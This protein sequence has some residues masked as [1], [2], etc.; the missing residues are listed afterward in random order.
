MATIMEGQPFPDVTITNTQVQKAPEYYT[1]Y[2][3]G[4]ASVG[5]DYLSKEG[6]DLVAGYDPLQTSGYDKI[7]TGAGAYASPLTSA[8]KNIGDVAGGIDVD[9]I[10][11]F[12]D[13]YKQ[14]VV[15]EMERQAQQQLQRSILPTL[16][17]GFVGSG[18]LG[19]Q[20]YAGALGQA[21]A[22]VQAN[23]TGQTYGA[24]SSG[25]KDALNAALQEAQT[26]GQAANIQGNLAEMS[27]RLGIGES[28]ALR[29]AGAEK[30]SYEQALIN[31]PLTTATNVSGLLR[32]YQ[33]PMEE[34]K[35]YF[36]P[37][38]SAY[39][40]KSPLEMYGPLI[41]GGLGLFGSSPQQ[42]AGGIKGTLGD[43]FDWAKN[44]DWRGLYNPSGEDYWGGSD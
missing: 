24:L 34:E 6:K 43:V 33:M 31:A 41:T 40:Q 8:Q 11:Q 7:T 37:Q 39:Y 19:G 10:S 12:M 21:L 4:L 27:Q 14:N 44:Y 1:D 3:S 13:P 28:E 32:G 5:E 36:G 25:Y 38:T 18:G 23:L 26:R 29:K 22:D 17:A 20:R 2:L 16:K 30:Q 35:V 9:R 15:Q 42:M